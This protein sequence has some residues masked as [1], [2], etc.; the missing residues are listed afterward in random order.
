LIPRPSGQSPFRTTSVSAAPHTKRDGCFQISAERRAGCLMPLPAPRAA[1]GAA[2]G[3]SRKSD[4]RQ[5]YK[6]NR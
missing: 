2:A 6:R 3:C 5:G 4:Q 1:P